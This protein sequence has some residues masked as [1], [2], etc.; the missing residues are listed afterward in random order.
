MDETRVNQ[1]IIDKLE[2]IQR[3]QIDTREFTNRAIV[4]IGLIQYEF[5]S[6]IM[7]KFSQRDER[8]NRYLITIYALLALQLL[9]LVLFGCVM[10]Y[11]IWAL[12]AKGAM[13]IVGW[14]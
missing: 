5:E 10:M 6:R 3:M 1:L 4:G 14:R 2:E 8:Q 12:S 11:L 9:L 7:D 13:P